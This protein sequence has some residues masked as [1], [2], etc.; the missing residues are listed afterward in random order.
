MDDVQALH[1]SH[2]LLKLMAIDM[3]KYPS[4]YRDPENQ[5]VTIILED[6]PMH[7]VWV[8]NEDGDITLY[9]AMDDNRVVGAF[10]PLRINELND[11]PAKKPIEAALSCEN[12]GGKFYDVWMVHKHLWEQSGLQGWCCIPCWEA[13]MGRL[14]KPEDLNN[15]LCNHNLPSYWFLTTRVFSP[16]H[17]K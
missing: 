11:N 2:F 1:R 6:V 4:I 10:L 7:A 13:K 12:C 3:P 16:N 5:R 17:P 14:I 9:R 15:A 8:G